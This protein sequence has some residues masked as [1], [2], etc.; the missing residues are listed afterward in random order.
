MAGAP[1]GTQGEGVLQ[2]NAETAAAIA[3][4]A[5]LSAREARE[6]AEAALRKQEAEAAEAAEKQEAEDVAAASAAAAATERERAKPRIDVMDADATWDYDPLADVGA[7][8]IIHE[9]TDEGEVQLA[10]ERVSRSTSAAPTSHTQ[11]GDPFQSSFYADAQ[12]QQTRGNHH[13]QQP[14]Q[15]QR[16]EGFGNSAFGAQPNGFG[17]GEFPNPFGPQPSN[18]GWRGF[19][20]ANGQPHHPHWSQSWQQ[21]HQQQHQHQHQQ[22]HTQQRAPNATWQQQNQQQQQARDEQRLQPQQQWARDNKP[23]QH[24]QNIAQVKQLL[25]GPHQREQPPEPGQPRP[26]QQKAR[27]NNSDMHSNHGKLWA[28]PAG[29]AEIT[30]RDDRISEVEVGL[31]GAARVSH[32]QQPQGRGAAAAD[33]VKGSGYLPPMQPAA[34]QH[35]EEQ[36]RG[37]Q[38]VL[39][40]QQLNERQA[41]QL[42][43]EQQQQGRSTVAQ[44]RSAMAMRSASPSLN[45]PRTASGQSS[46][47]ATLDRLANARSAANSGAERLRQFKQPQSVVFASRFSSQS[48]RPYNPIAMSAAPSQP[49]QQLAREHCNAGSSTGRPQPHEGPNLPASLPLQEPSAIDAIG[50]GGLGFRGAVT[51]RMSP[52]EQMRR[53]LAESS[54]ARYADNGGAR[55]S[56]RRNSQGG[57]TPAPVRVESG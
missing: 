34:R 11:G 19:G 4:V 35:Q 10:Y 8:V 50:S 24:R 20:S 32:D 55:S 3:A 49:Q 17:G 2:E 23:S 52:A 26:Q 29:T 45:R 38:Q 16:Q 28:H 22:H 53:Q 57:D 6:A 41:G 15:Q 30:P 48:R 25:P 39:Q 21:Q 42:A 46:A 47:E 9:V 44:A 31:E 33:D 5:E 56:A 1:D 13:Q 54:A 37:Q 40:H 18:D 7:S 43:R 27:D 36:A 51:P 14:H 12:Q